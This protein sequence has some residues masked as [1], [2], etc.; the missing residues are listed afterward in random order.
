M[1]G[2]TGEVLV[3]YGCGVGSIAAA[4]VSEG[5][6]RVIAIDPD[7]GALGNVPETLQKAGFDGKVDLVQSSSMVPLALDDA[8]V[9]SIVSG[10]GAIIYA[11]Y[12]LNGRMLEGRDALRE[13]LRE[14]HRTLKP[15]GYLAFS[16]LVPEPDFKRIKWETIWSLFRKG[17]FRL[18]AKSLPSAK[19]VEQISA[20]MLDC[21]R[22]GKAHYL[23][24][25]EWKNVLTFT[26]FEVV[27]IKH[28]GYAGQGMAIVARRK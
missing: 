20:F 19:T 16:S 5:F 9:D 27:T 4:L 7:L 13:C 17:E 14:C 22:S 23:T 1:M 6:G 2:K 28:G 15:G 12:F 24:E 26:D 21:A 10:L 11:G 3:D 8:S 25:Q 18:L